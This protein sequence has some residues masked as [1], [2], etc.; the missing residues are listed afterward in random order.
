MYRKTIE[1]NG[2][3]LF[4]IK[5]KG[6]RKVKGKY[7]EINRGLNIKEKIKVLIAIVLYCTVL[8][9]TALYCTALYFYTRFGCNMSIQLF[10]QVKLIDTNHFSEICEDINK[11]YGLLN[12]NHGVKYFLIVLKSTMVG[13]SAVQ[14]TTF[15][16]RKESKL[17]L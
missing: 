1:K 7:L 9:C 8:H 15:R 12:M 5:V 2:D 16:P 10:N 11:E 6:Q 13:M 14:Y 17:Y 3:R 4:S